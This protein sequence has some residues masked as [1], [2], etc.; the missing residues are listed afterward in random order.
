MLLW[1]ATNAE[2]L[3]VPGSKVPYFGLIIRWVLRVNMANLLTNEAP[4]GIKSV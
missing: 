4:K 3:S 1:G 2:M